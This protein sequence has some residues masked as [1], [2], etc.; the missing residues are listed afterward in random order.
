MDGIASQFLLRWEKKSSNEYSM[1]GNFDFSL[2][3]VP[4]NEKDTAIN[5]AAQPFINGYSQLNSQ[6]RS[7]LKSGDGLL[8]GELPINMRESVQEIVKS[9]NRF[10]TFDSQ[11]KD[12]SHAH[13]TVMPTKTSNGILEMFITIAMP[14]HSYGHSITNAPALVKAGVIKKNT[15]TIYTLE[16]FDIPRSDYPNVRVVSTWLTL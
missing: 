13:I 11:I 5:D 10:E 14:G 7:T 8:L 12:T 9:V 16:K 1:L 15:P 6:M 4:D 2:G 3:W